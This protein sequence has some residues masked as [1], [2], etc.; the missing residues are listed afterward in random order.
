[1]LISVLEADGNRDVES[2]PL[3]LR[4]YNEY[5]FCVGLDHC[6]KTE[7]ESLF[8]LKGSKFLQSPEALTHCVPSFLQTRRGLLLYHY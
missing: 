4:R 2:L 1:M 8:L 5:A 3:A 6:H 7:S